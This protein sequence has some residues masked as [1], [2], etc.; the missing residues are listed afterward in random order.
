MKKNERKIRLQRFEAVWT[1]GAHEL[2]TTD[3]KS[4]EETEAGLA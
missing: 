2:I 1:C 3:Y 4:V